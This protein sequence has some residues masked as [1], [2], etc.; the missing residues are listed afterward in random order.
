MQQNVFLQV[1]YAKKSENQSLHAS[2]KKN[3]WSPI[4]WYSGNEYENR[5]KKKI[6]LTTMLFIYIY[7][8]T[9]ELNYHY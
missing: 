5:N 7:I 4:I 1:E 3:D 2:E 9:N 6:F 8:Y